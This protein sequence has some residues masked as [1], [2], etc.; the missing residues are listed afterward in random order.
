[1]EDDE[2]KL[3]T[4]DYFN[5]DINLLAL[6]IL[7]EGF[8]KDINVFTLDQFLK[9][10]Y[11]KID[12]INQEIQDT[13]DYNSVE[14]LVLHQILGIINDLSL[15]KIER[16]SVVSISEI[17]ETT[18]EKALNE[19][20][21]EEGLIL[22]YT[23]IIEELCKFEALKKSRLDRD[24]AIGIDFQKAYKN[25]VDFTEDDFFRNVQYLP[26]LFAPF[27]E[28]M[29]SFSKENIE[30]IKKE[31]N[32]C[33]QAFYQDKYIETKPFYKNKRLYFSKQLENFVEYIK[34]FPILENN[35]NIPFSTLSEQGFE[36]IKILS[37]L[38]RERR[39][40]VRN[41]N[42]TELWNVKFKTIPITF[43]SILGQKEVKQIETSKEIKLSLSFSS[44]SGIITIIDQNKKEYKIKIQGQVQKE[45]LRVIFENPK[46]TYSDWSLY[47][48]SEILGRDDVN[49]VAVKNAIY[50]FNRKVKISIPQIENIFELT[51]HSCRLNPKYIDKN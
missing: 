33:I 49:E 22:Y 14:E 5:S 41:W 2:E 21:S 18:I 29:V 19:K 40:K 17:L 37:Y 32:D 38:E 39:I 42:D 12:E 13:N 8:Y 44:S 25:G 31:I 28:I 3:N 45:V 36:I 48:I 46:N 11:W 1:M 24:M 16:I 10:D 50:Q 4:F 35:V 34:D 20:E 47:E 6:N 26:S 51:K 23:G 27:I 43:A 9:G 15:G 30:K 7:F